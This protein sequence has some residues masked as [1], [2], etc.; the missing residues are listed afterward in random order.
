LK[1]ESMAEVRS[2]VVK[3]PAAPEVAAQDAEREPSGSARPLRVPLSWIDG[4]G[5]LED[6]EATGA[7]CGALGSRAAVSASALPA[8]F[9][10]DGPQAIEAL[11]G[12]DGRRTWGFRHRRLFRIYLACWSVIDRICEPP[13]FVALSPWQ[14][15]D[16]E[17]LLEPEAV[18]ALEAALP[19]RYRLIVALM[20]WGGLRWCEVAGLTRRA[21]RPSRGRIRILADGDGH[22]G[23]LEPRAL[24][25]R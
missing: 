1:E 12:P 9:V 16:A 13:M 20:R 25:Y 8:G 22:R 15:P 14:C 5:G 23:T 18:A 10:A 4:W 7:S 2:D 24:R 19:D 11:I 6:P 21:C 17:A 3:T